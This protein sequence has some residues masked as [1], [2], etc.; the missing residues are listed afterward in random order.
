MVLRSDLIQD[1]DI[2]IL[3]I[4]HQGNPTT[5]I[6]NLYNDHKWHDECATALL[7]TIPL[8][9]NQ[10]TII[11]GDWD[12]H[13]YLWSSS[14]NINSSMETDCMVDWLMIHGY[15]L[16]NIPGQHTYIPHTSWGTALVLDLTFVNGLATQHT[17]PSNWTIKLE[18]VFDS[19]HLAIQWILF[20]NVTPISNCC[21]NRYNI[22][23]TDKNAWSTAFVKILE[24]FWGPL[25]VLMDTNNPIS[26]TNLENAVLAF[27]TAIICTN[28]QVVKKYNSSSTAKL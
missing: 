17:I 11:T 19:D 23:D 6:I 5:T 4:I 3:N 28:K 21:G 26:I 9:Q 13:H 18:F 7:R 25:N 14:P 12:M 15:L 2:Q 22:K 16:S 27:L 10:P 24:H 8:S 20:N 1:R